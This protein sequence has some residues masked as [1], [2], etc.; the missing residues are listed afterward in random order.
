MG[1]LSGFA[2][3]QDLLW[4][5]IAFANRSVDRSLFSHLIVVHSL[6]PS[7]SVQLITRFMICSK[8]INGIDGA[9]DGEQTPG[10][11]YSE[12]VKMRADFL[13]SSEIACEALP[14]MA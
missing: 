10:A 3:A 12:V 8:A 9:R 7:L 6:D 4:I 2:I 14:G 1:S 13:T 11:G 5:A